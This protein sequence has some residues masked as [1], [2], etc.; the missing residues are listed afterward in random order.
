MILRKLTVI[1]ITRV[2][3]KRLLLVFL[4]CFG[5]QGYGQIN[6]TDGCPTISVLPVN[7]SCVQNTYFMSGTFTNGALIAPSC[8]GA[9]SNRDDGWYSFVATATAITIEEVSTDRTHLIQVYTACGAS[10]IAGSC[11]LNT[12]NNINTVN[13]TGLT[14]GVTYYIQLQRRSGLGTDNMN[15]TICVYTTPN[16]DVAWPGQTLG[17]IACNA[18]TTVSGNTTGATIHCT[19]SSAGDHIYQF[20]T[21]SNADVTIS[22]CSSS[23]D[24]EIKLFNLTNGNCDSGP[25]ATNDDACG[26]QSSLA[27][28]CLT[29][30]TY[31]VV[32]E[33]SGVAEGAYTM[34]INVTD[35]GCTGLVND[36]PCF[37][38]ALPVGTSCSFT[39]DNNTGA[40]AT[41]VASP[42][43]AN[44]VDDDLW[45]SITV[46]AGGWV[47]FETSA[48]TL[49]DGGM[50]IYSG[51]CAAPTLIEC[52]DNSGPGSMPQIERMDLTPGST[53]LI[54]FWENGGNFNG[55]YNICA[56]YPD[57]STDATNDFCADAGILTPS[58]GSTFA[59]STASIYTADQPDNIATEF[60]GT[61]QNNS[62]YQFVAT[63][64]THTFPITTVVG[65]TNGIQAEVYDFN[66][67]SS[68]CCNT[69]NSVSNCYNPGNTSLGTVTATGLTIGNTYMLMIDGWAGANCDFAISDWTATNILPVQLVNFE[70]KTNAHFNHVMWHTKSELN[71]KWF[72][73]ER[74]SDGINYSEIGTLDA[75]GN[76]SQEL[77]Y[78]FK[79]YDFMHPKLYYRLKEIDYDGSVQYSDAVMI[80]RTDLDVSIYPNPTTGVVNFSFYNQTEADYSVKYTDAM[81][82]IV[83]EEIKVAE[84]NSTYTSAILANLPNGVYFVEVYDGSGNI[85][86]QEKLIKSE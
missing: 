49:T 58:A 44:Y 8:G 22:L 47:I 48:G 72:V 19:E 9:T 41:A 55:S 11:A 12:A 86:L 73:I 53:I 23:Y 75:A 35:C 7:A 74:S 78:N 62:W 77:F 59:S 61:I 3:P 66:G 64:T 69:F 65:C 45:Y 25:I 2:M 6:P 83:M 31:V 82:R 38:T 21:T 13:L 52:N 56:H 36:N 39:A 26:V 27:M 50:A 1:I 40:T 70:V 29:A 14:I 43:C 34:S 15:G 81:G 60:C 71:S 76:S 42:G 32:V 18:T 46:P 4:I 20:T 63:S 24:T 16:P 5:I 51:G 68:L 28:T 37:A 33:G 84:G 85:V 54:R 80:M 30:G 17:T 67:G 10:P 57:C 79:D